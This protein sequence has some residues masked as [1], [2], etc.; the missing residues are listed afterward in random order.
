[1]EVCNRRVGPDYL[2]AHAVAQES[3]SCSTSAWLLERPAAISERPR[4]MAAMMCN[5]SVISASDS[6]SGSLLR[7]SI[8]ACLSVMGADYLCTFPNARDEAR[9]LSSHHGSD[10]RSGSLKRVRR[11]VGTRTHRGES[12]DRRL[13]CHRSSAAVGNMRYPARSVGCRCIMLR[14]RPTSWR[15]PSRLQ[16]AHAH[17]LRPHGLAQRPPGRTTGPGPGHPRVRKRAA[18]VRPVECSC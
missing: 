16:T 6:T 18:P 4:R 11:L 3:T 2:E 17:V 15:R 7:A 1:M 5:S 14:K 8:T 9:R 10:A 12:E 13:E